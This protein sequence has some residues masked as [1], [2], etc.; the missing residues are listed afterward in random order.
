[1]KVTQLLARKDGLKDH[2]TTFAK[3]RVHLIGVPPP[4]LND[5]DKGLICGRS[6]RNGNRRILHVKYLRRKQYRR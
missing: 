6:S 2:D 3:N 5:T 4:A 1:M